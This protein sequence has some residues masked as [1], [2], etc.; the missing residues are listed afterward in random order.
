MPLSR[1]F[2]FYWASKDVAGL[3]NSILFVALVTLGYQVEEST[4]IASIIVVAMLLPPFLLTPLVDRFV[5]GRRAYPTT[6][7]ASL[8]VIAALLPLTT[9]ATTAQLK[10]V[11]AATFAAAIPAA[12]LKSARK[13]M[14][15]TII[16]NELAAAEKALDTTRIITLIVG[17]AAGA[18]LF[19]S[20]NFGAAG[21]STCAIAAIIAL[22]VSTVLLIFSRPS[23]VDWPPFQPQPLA[24]KLAELQKGLV[25]TWQLPALRTVATIH[26]GAALLVGV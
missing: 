7:I 23:P 3:G 5:Y 18:Y 10:L 25:Y 9:V 26:L 13:A 16:G 21:F 20:A 12:F 17:P 2:Y 8:A 22:S 24:V 14:L 4:T 11:L 6:L 15:P 19:G 1:A